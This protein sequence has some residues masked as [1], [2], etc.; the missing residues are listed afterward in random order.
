MSEH[1]VVEVEGF[2]MVGLHYRGTNQHQ[3]V[4]ALWDAFVPRMFE[5]KDWAADET[6]GFCTNYD[7]ASGEFDYYAGAAVHQTDGQPADMVSTTV[8]GGT[9]V[10]T[11]GRLS[12]IGALMHEATE[13]AKA[14]GT[15]LGP[16][17]ELYPAQFGEGGNDQMWV[18]VQI[19]R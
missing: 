17:Y 15:V 3:E 8:P 14:R 16:M 19:G 9:Y 12:E 2:T 1:K 6:Y 4:K 10:A 18:Y 5:V 11:E 7:A 13:N